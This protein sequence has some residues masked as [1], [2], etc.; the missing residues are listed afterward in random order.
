MTPKLETRPPETDP[1]AQLDA[2][3]D[4]E[5]RCECHCQNYVRPHGKA[6]CTKPA[7]YY[8]EA[9]IFGLCRHPEA[10]ADPNVTDDGD[11]CAYLCENCYQAAIA[12]AQAELAKLPK[13]IRVVCP[14]APARMGCGRPIATLDDYVPVRRPL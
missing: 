10:L 7:T 1:L 5:R 3:L 6:R 9:H 11:R 4:A 13:G 12:H 14:P 2:E 8:V